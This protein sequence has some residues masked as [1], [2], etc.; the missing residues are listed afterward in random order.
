[1][2][3]SVE[4]RERDVGTVVFKDGEG[5]LVRQR[6]LWDQAAGCRIERPDG[7]VFIF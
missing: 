3:N 2:R 6:W 5:K 4:A 7:G 1:M